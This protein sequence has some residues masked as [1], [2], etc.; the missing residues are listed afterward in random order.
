MMLPTAFI[1]LPLSQS[2]NLRNHFILVTALQRS[3]AF[4]NHFLLIHSVSSLSALVELTPFFLQAFMSWTEYLIRLFK[5]TD[6]FHYVSKVNYFVFCPLLI[7]LLLSVHADF[8]YH[9]K[10]VSSHSPTAPCC[11]EHGLHFS[12]DTGTE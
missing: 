6:R 12:C 3:P 9:L 5:L 2:V 11:R 1:I 10:A 8:R 7:N 4:G